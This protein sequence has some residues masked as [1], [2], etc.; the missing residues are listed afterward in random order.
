M[1]NILLYNMLKK[2]NYKLTPQRKKI[3]DILDKSKD[4]FLNVNELDNEL[5]KQD[6]N[7][8]LTT[9]Y[10][11]LEIME[12]LGIIHSHSLDNFKMYKITCNTHHHHHLIC[13]KCSKTYS[14]SFC[15]I[16]ELEKIAKKEDFY[17]TN[18]TIDVYGLCSK[19]KT[20]DE[21]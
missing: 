12:D 6:I 3:L 21:K 18:H 5:K 7:M 14:F 4:K 8:N 19:C 2:S 13:T 11:N 20:K 17:I 1:K 9:I 16:D 15:P 10:R